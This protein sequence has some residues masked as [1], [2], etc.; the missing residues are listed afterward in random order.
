MSR[1]LWPPW[2]AIHFHLL[3]LTLLKILIHPFLLSLSLS[4]PGQTSLPRAK[5]DGRT[6]GCRTCFV[7]CCWCCCYE[8]EWGGEIDDNHPEWGWII[9]FLFISLEDYR[10]LSDECF[11]SVRPSSPCSR[12]LSF[13]I[14]CL[15]CCAKTKAGVS[16][17]KESGPAHA[18]VCGAEIGIALQRQSAC[19]FLKQTEVFFFFPIIFF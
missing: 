3:S 16:V 1:K 7:R 18:F 2:K 19:R 8:E 11:P 4:Q 9:L 17:Q 12:E 13:G 6:D 5:T 15:L 14:L 10:V